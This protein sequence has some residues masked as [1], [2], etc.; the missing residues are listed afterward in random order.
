MA[1]AFRNGVVDDVQVFV[2]YRRD[3]HVAGHWLILM[4]WIVNQVWLL[5]RVQAMAIIF[6]GACL[7]AAEGAPGEFQNIRE[8]AQGQDG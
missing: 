1:D 2:A 3:I 6:F 8:Y 7:A 5:T 4:I